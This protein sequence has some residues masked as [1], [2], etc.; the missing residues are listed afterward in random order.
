MSADAPC[1]ECGKLAGYSLLGDNLRDVDSGWIRNVMVGLRV[2][3]VAYIFFTIQYLLHYLPALGVR[4][5]DF[6]AAV[7][8][9]CVALAGWLAIIVGVFMVTAPE[10]SGSLIAR[11]RL[12]ATILR[13]TTVLSAV[14]FFVPED[15]LHR[16]GD[17]GF[18]A[19]IIVYSVVLLLSQSL[20][21]LH[22]RTIVARTP[23]REVY[24]ALSIALVLTVAIYVAASRAV[25]HLASRL[26]T[27]PSAPTGLHLTQVSLRLVHYA[28]AL[29]LLPLTLKAIR[30]TIGY[31]DN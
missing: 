16:A 27:T 28:M 30:R 29:F 22:L 14:E 7:I 17:T 25:L 31:W 20:L 23:R 19:A 11:R 5:S 13:W 26:A 2:I 9:N 6:D 1:P 15:W 10:S 4:E 21:W 12:L 18:I 24:K 8:R 3:A